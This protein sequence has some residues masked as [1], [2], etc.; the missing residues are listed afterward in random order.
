M[1]PM[2]L[3]TLV[4]PAPLG[5]ISANSSGPSRAN[6]TPSSTIKPL[7][8]RL[9]PSTCRSAIPSP[10]AS[11]LLDCAIAASLSA[12][13]LSEIE[14]LHIL[15]VAQPMAVAVEHDAPV[16]HDVTVVGEGKRHGHALFYD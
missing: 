6:D 15:M 7:K 16:L 13:R 2:Q 4:L 12:P 3:S 11:V 9:R 10:A 8:R 14:L 1:P 5:P